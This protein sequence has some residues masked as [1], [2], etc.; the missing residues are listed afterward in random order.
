[1]T[2]LVFHQKNLEREVSIMIYSV[3]PSE[4]VCARCGCSLGIPYDGET[5]YCFNKYS[6]E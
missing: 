5:H 6:C 1:M 3:L 2:I 4:S